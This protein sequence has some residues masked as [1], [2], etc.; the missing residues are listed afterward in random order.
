M[1]L[2]YLWYYSTKTRSQI[3]GYSLDLSNNNDFQRHVFSCISV[4]KYIYIYTYWYIYTYLYTH[5]SPKL[6]IF[7]GVF[8][9]VCFHGRSTRLAVSGGASTNLGF[10]RWNT[11]AG[12]EDST[13]DLSNFSPADREL[14]GELFFWWNFW[15]E[16]VR[17]DVLKEVMITF[18]VNCAC[19]YMFC[20]FCLV[21]FSSWSMF[22][23]MV[24]S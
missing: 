7:Q 18:Q 20:G 23:L 5:T 14:P 24:F 21:F 2:I 13:W 6:E 4:Y 3:D 9:L 16:T 1:L 22:P 10:E 12:S 19:F 11:R 15:M 17:K 8:R